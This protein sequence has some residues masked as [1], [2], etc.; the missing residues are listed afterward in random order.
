[1]SKFFISPNVR[2][3]WYAVEILRKILNLVIHESDIQGHCG[4]VLIFLK[5]WQEYF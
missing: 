3:T 1:M 5:N 4:I 2:H